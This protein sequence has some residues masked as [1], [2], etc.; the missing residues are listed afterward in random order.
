M[1]TFGQKYVTI[2]SRRYFIHQEFYNTF[3]LFAET[4]FVYCTEVLILNASTVFY[5]NNK[6]ILL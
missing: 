2:Y 3:P 5:L 6:A 1:L 4:T